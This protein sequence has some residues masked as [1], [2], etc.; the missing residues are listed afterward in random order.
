MSVIIIIRRTGIRKVGNESVTSYMTDSV[1]VLGIYVT[2][3][4]MSDV[5]LE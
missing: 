3:S 2:K 1:N 4:H 5:R